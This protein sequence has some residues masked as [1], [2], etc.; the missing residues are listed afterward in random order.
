[1]AQQALR[2]VWDKIWKRQWEKACGSENGTDLGAGGGNG[3]ND[4]I[5]CEYEVKEPQREVQI[6]HVSTLSRRPRR[7][8]G[9]HYYI[10]ALPHDAPKD[11]LS[12]LQLGDT[13]LQE[14]SL[15]LRVGGL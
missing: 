1:M 12:V 13:V 6:G 4:G 3:V 15:S 2:R 9:A 5:K 10:A 11:A 14:L 7:Q 8:S